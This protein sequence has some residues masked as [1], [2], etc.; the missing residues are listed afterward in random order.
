VVP[1]GRVTLQVN[2]V[3]H[4]RPRLTGIP[5]EVIMLVLSRKVGEEIIVDNRIT[6]VVTKVKGNSVQIGINAPKEVPILRGELV[7]VE[8]GQEPG[9]D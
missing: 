7:G 4:T 5:M 9:E 8:A 3:V 2:M 6:I 1:L